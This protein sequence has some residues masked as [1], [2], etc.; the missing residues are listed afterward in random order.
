M[1]ERERERER[2]PHTHARLPA[3]ASAPAKHQ[4]RQ[5][6]QQKSKPFGWR[7]RLPHTDNGDWFYKAPLILLSF[8]LLLRRIR[9][10]SR[11]RLRKRRERKVH[12]DES[13]AVSN[14]A[15]L[16]N[17]KSAFCRLHICENDVCGQQRAAY[18]H[19]ISS[20]S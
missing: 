20:F 14:F 19:W 12:P 17:Y 11:P 15:R 5:R 2:A 16:R 10:Y 9:I 13:K 4:L 7:R 18:S 6:R 1:R 3:A 8:M